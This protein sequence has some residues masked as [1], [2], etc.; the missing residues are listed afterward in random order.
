LKEGDTI[1]AVAKQEALKN[2]FGFYTI[3]KKKE[4]TVVALFKGTV[5][6][7]DKEWEE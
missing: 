2:K 4:N 3:E 7:S 6:R 5:F 1:V